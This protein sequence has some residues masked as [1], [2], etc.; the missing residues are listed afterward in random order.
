MKRNILFLFIIITGLISCK[1]KESQV[2]NHIPTFFPLTQSI[3]VKDFMPYIDSV[4]ILPLEATDS[5]FIEDIKK[6][7]VTPSGQMI[8][9]NTSGILLFDEK[10]HFLFPVGTQGRGPEEYLHAVDICLNESA[11][12]VWALDKDKSVSKYALSNGHFIG[13][14]IPRFS[15]NYPDCIGIAPAS[16]EGFFLFGCNPYEK[17]D[18]TTPFYCLN[19][20]DATGKHIDSLLLRKAYVLPLDAITQSYDNSYLIR[21]QE[22][23]KVCYR[24][25]GKKMDAIYQF[26]FGRKYMP[27]S[28]G[29]I[30]PGQHFDIQNYVNAPYYKLPMYIHETAD[31]LYF[32]CGGPEANDHFYV[33]NKTT[34]QGI[35][36]VHD[37]KD[38]TALLLA[39]ASDK[40]FFYYIFND[41]NDYIPESLPI[42]ME[43]LK[44]YLIK[45]KHVNL[46][47][48][49]MNPL[50]IKIK[51]KLP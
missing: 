21:P 12:E 32:S 42:E 13:K 46:K 2:Q 35:H 45:E 23:D 28:L 15:T 17:S 41:Y 11:T 44:R 49:S 22:G 43:P 7:L 14:I 5:S 20:F 38:A 16:K 25:K 36:W 34:L 19:L 29:K 47:G 30:R 18:F 50:I 4:A 51:F 8:I 1:S 26:D 40:D 10:G 39:K 31:Q 3:Q 27:L 37:K 48:D 33:F 9:L 6:I 24:L